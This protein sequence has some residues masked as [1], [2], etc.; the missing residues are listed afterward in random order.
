MNAVCRPLDFDILHSYNKISPNLIKLGL[1]CQQ[2]R[3]I[4]LECGRGCI[5]GGQGEE[6]GH[7]CNSVHNKKQKA[8]NPIC[9][10]WLEGPYKQV[11][12]Y[13]FDLIPNQK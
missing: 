5:E 2:R 12:A 6:M 11:P 10:P 7:I 1:F 3:E 8:Y 13:L 9:F 4:Q